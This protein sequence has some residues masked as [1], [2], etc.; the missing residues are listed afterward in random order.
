MKKRFLK[1]RIY[2]FSL[3]RTNSCVDTHTLQMP[4]NYSKTGFGYKHRPGK[5]VN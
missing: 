1:R 3:A 4:N 2:F 5:F